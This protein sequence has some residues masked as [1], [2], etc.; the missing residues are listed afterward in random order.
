MTA[1]APGGT[2]ILLVEISSPAAIEIGRLG[3]LS[4]DSGIYAYVGSAFGPGGLESRLRRYTAGPR[5]NHWHIDYLLDRSEVR[6]ALVS[7]SQERLECVWAQWMRDRGLILVPG[8]GSSDCRCKSHLFFV[9]GNARAEEIIRTAGCELKAILRWR[10]V[11]AYDESLD[12]RITE[13][14]ASWGATKKKMFGGTCHLLHGN[15]LCGVHEDRLI[16]RLG[17][18]AGAAALEE[19]HTRPFDITGRPMNGWVM[20]AP[21]GYAGGGLNAWL[22]KARAFVATLPPK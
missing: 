5:R 18:K 15:M 10:S 4:F 12:A 19:P 9:G 3:R 16:V 7:N 22:E 2:Y 14:V 21:Q 20:V 8:F 13:A 6:T 11:M 1:P 17:L